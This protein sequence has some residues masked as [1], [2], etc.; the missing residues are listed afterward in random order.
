MF[1]EKQPAMLEDMPDFLTVEHGILHAIGRYTEL[2]QRAQRMEVKVLRRSLRLNEPIPW[3]LFR[4]HQ[5]NWLTAYADVG[6]L[7]LVA[8]CDCPFGR[9]GIYQLRIIEMLHSLARH[10]HVIDL[11]PIRE[12]GR[13]RAWYGWR[14]TLAQVTE[15]RRR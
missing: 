14:L 11:Q 8:L 2:V 10:A 4:P 12:R 3:K 15:P 6:A 9:M 5:I 1:V 13:M 7:A